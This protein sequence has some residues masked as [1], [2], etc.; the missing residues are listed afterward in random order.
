MD[1]MFDDMIIINADMLIAEIEGDIKEWL[2]NN[3][4]FICDCGNYE[5]GDLVLLPGFNGHIRCV[6]NVEYRFLADR[7]ILKKQE[8]GKF[9]FYKSR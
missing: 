4:A 8:D 7:A 6:C 1:Q 5:F 3:N 2:H 9:C